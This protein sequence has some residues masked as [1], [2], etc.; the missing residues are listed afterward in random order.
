MWLSRAFA[1]PCS[2]GRYADSFP[3][4]NVDPV[5]ALRYE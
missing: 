4:G 1:V 3:R 2:V 5:V